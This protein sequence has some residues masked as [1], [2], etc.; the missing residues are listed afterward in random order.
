VAGQSPSGKG[1]ETANAAP[2]PPAN[3]VPDLRKLVA[4]TDTAATKLDA[5]AIEKTA[6]QQPRKEGMT[7]AQKWALAL[8][9]IGT[10]ALVFVL[11]KNADSACIVTGGTAC[12]G[13]NERCTCRN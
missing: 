9:I 8:G 11:V 2:D 12:V 13:V 6:R 10:A 4:Q 1:I 5:K 7:A 3:N